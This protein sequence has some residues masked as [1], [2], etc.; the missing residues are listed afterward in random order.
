MPW[1]V[2][3]LHAAFAANLL[4]SV[5]V[6]ARILGGYARRAFS[7]DIEARWIGRHVTAIAVSHLLLLAWTTLRFIFAW[8]NWSWPWIIA[9]GAILLLSDFGLLQLYRYR[10]WKE[11]RAERKSGEMQAMKRPT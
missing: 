7:G 1:W 2:L 8:R 11:R 4:F 6:S 10:R 9:L 3:F 5:G